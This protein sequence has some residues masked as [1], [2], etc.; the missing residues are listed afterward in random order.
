MGMTEV[1]N[2][3]PVKKF[4]TQG[5]TETCPQITLL[6]DINLNEGILIKCNK[7]SEREQWLPTEVVKAASS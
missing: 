5:E 7:S 3:V 4:T 2:L 1:K 6:E